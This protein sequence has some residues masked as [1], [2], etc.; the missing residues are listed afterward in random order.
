M[1][2]IKISC[3]SNKRIS[4]RAVSLFFCLLLTMLNSSCKTMEVLGTSA[5]AACGTSTAY[6]S[7][8]QSRVSSETPILYDPVGGSIL[9]YWVD[10]A[11]NACHGI[12][13]QNGQV[14]SVRIKAFKQQVEEAYFNGSSLN[15][16]MLKSL[17]SIPISYGSYTTV[18]GLHFAQF[19]NKYNR[20]R[21][22]GKVERV[23]CTVSIPNIIEVGIKSCIV[24]VGLRV[25]APMPLG[26]PFIDQNSQDPS[27]CKNRVLPS[28]PIMSEDDRIMN[29]AGKLQD[30]NTIYDIE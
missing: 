11:G 9:V 7:D 13:G 25:T 28:G 27:R 16:E 8:W 18:P 3:S 12:P 19:Y 6:L 10:E 4:S 22:D 14:G 5:S 24:P 15:Q 1:K 26:S 23:C 30:G 2:N 20:I 17:Q 21:A 29:E